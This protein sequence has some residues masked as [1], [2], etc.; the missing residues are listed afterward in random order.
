MQ[1]VAFFRR[2]FRAEGLGVFLF[3]GLSLRSTPGFTPVQSGHMVYTPDRA[4][5]L[6]FMV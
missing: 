3:L 4:H 6:R 5:G 1:P 2:P